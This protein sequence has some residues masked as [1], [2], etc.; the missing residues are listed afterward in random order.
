MGFLRIEQETIINFNE[1]E[2]DASLYAA[3]PVM[4]RKLDKIVE[5][6]PEQ[7]RYGRFEYY[8]GKVYAKRYLFPKEFVCIRTKKPSSNWTEE[9]RQRAR[10]R[11]KQIQAEKKQNMSQN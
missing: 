11:M 4:M 8:Q 5:E 10:E 9:R 3:S 6:N 2:A 7:F 1:G